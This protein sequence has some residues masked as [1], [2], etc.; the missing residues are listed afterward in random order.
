MARAKKRDQKA[1]SVTA[2][3]IEPERLSEEDI[4]ERKD[5]LIAKGLEQRFVTQQDI[6]EVYPHPDKDVED[7]NA[8]Y[9][10]FLEMGIAILGP[11]D[12]RPTVESDESVPDIEV[13]APQRAAEESGDDD[14]VRL[15]LREIG[16]VPLLTGEEEQEL[17]RAVQQGLK[18]AE[19]LSK[20]KANPQTRSLLL[21]QVR[22]GQEAQRRLAEANLRLVVSV[23]KRYAGRGMSL[24]D[25]VQEGNMGLLHAVEKFDY[26]KGFKF[27][28]YGT[29]WIRQAINRAIAEQARTIRLPAHMIDTI[30]RVLRAS[31]ELSQTLGREPTAEELALKMGLLSPE[32]A[33]AV[34]EARIS[35]EPL[36]PEVRRALTLASSKVREV[37]RIVQ[38]PMSLE[39]PVGTEDTSEL[40]DFIEDETIP[41]P[42]DEASRRL[43]REQ[44]R[45]ILSLLTKR[46]REVLSLRFG[47][48]DGQG[49]TLEEVGKE[50]QITRERVRQIEAKALRKLRHPQRSRKL[51]DYLT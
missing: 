30:N 7:R 26:R 21:P 1:A 17:A 13:A 28:T 25:L 2:S 31:Q 22:K 49:R 12:D 11:D 40:G 50:F 14:P 4:D 37:L 27:S 42:A 34:E 38:E 39:M 48:E 16:R 32:E 47:L 19:Q 45:D 15:Y 3:H 44:M 33:E 35:G 24:L 10:A 5:R 23:A 9:A 6:D 20:G 29:W 51:K 8:L 46:E 36:D 41:G 43:L 18:A